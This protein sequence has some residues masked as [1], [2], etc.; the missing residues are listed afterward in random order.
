MTGVST[1]EEHASLHARAGWCVATC[2]TY[3]ACYG[4]C[5]HVTVARAPVPTLAFAWE[6]SIP[7]VPAFVVPYWS[8]DVLF[9]GSFFLCRR[10]GELRALVK[11][12]AFVLAV[13]TACFLLFPL[14]MAWR[15]PPIEGAWAVLFAPLDALDRPY[16]LA[17]SLH[18]AEWTV[19]WIV[20]A[21]RTGGW[22]SG[23][24]AVWFLLIAASTLLTWQ[25]HAFDV[26]TGHAL[27]LAAL[28]LFRERE[29]LRATH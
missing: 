13:A 1:D 25:H 14:Q 29:P 17:P 28:Y 15:R 18:I 12:L 2:V 6:R 27:G 9:A 19:V 23:A 8:L 24:L 20:Y 7:L 11:R 26:I 10:N 3:L 21:R 16:T 5:L 22:L 4:A